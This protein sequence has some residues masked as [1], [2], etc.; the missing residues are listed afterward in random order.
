MAKN[1]NITISKDNKTMTITVDLSKTFGT[2]VS[3]KSTIIASTEGNI[4]AIE[5]KLGQVMVGLNVYA[6]VKKK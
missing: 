2:S 6:P 3:G 5:N 4:A 1:A